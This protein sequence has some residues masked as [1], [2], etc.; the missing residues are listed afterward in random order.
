M[1]YS[2]CVIKL[3]PQIY[4]KQRFKQVYLTHTGTQIKLNVTMTDANN[5]IQTY[6]YRT[7]TENMSGMTYA[8]HESI[9]LVYV[10]KIMVKMQNYM[11]LRQI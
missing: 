4:L 5:V 8:C 1:N 3:H 10:I 9:T 2:Q 11:T 7:L 6:M